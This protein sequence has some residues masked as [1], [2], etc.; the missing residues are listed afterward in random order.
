[1]NGRFSIAYLLAARPAALA[2]ALVAGWLGVSGV[3][4]QQPIGVTS[5]LERAATTSPEEKIAYAENANTEIAAAIKTIEKLLDTAKRTNASPDALQCLN[6]RLTQVRTL[7]AVSIASEGTM[8]EALAVQEIESAN[9]EFRKVAIALAKTRGLLAEA[10]TCTG[11]EEEAT[12][13]TT[14]EVTQPDQFP[15]IGN[16]DDTF[17][18]VVDLPGTPGPE[19]A[20]L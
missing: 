20:I 11:Q 12:G 14:S 9:H 6:T 19:T 15:E 3:A 10:Y 1:M 2:A 17:D 13:Q 4:A 16:P 8:R 7:A 5:E 18:G